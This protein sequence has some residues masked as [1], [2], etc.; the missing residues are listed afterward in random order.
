MSARTHA[1]V[2]GRVAGGCARVRVSKAGGRHRRVTQVAGRSRAGH[3]RVTC[4]SRA[5]HVR[6]T[7]LVQDEALDEVGGRDYVDRP[8]E[9][10]PDGEGRATRK[11][12]GKASFLNSTGPGRASTSPWTRPFEAGTRPA[13]A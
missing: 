1:R 8:I 12:L 6:V 3:V 7:C 11:G 10:A 5:G 13:H 9:D 2:S 4:G